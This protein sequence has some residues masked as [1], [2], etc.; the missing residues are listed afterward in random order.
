VEHLKGDRD[1]R[2]ERVDESLIAEIRAGVKRQAI[3]PGRNGVA[4]GQRRR[5]T[6]SVGDTAG[7][8]APLARMTNLENDG[9]PR[10]RLSSS[11]VQDVSGNHSVCSR[12]VVELLSPSS[13]AILR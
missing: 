2:K 9:H 7:D 1:L 8:R 10:C 5:A 13:L 3:C 12:A 4:L 6:L 11:C